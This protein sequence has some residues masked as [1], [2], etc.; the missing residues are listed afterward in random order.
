MD[1]LKPV[2]EKE[3][4]QVPMMLKACSVLGETISQCKYSDRLNPSSAKG[5]IT[6]KKSSTVPVVLN[7]QDALGLHTLISFSSCFYVVYIYRHIC[8]HGS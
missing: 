3:S 7:C 6:T 2:E 5:P 8:T 1:C 4:R